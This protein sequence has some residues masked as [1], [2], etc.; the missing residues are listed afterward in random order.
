MSFYRLALNGSPARG[1]SPIGGQQQYFLSSSSKIL[2]Y[3]SDGDTNG[4]FYWLGTSGGTQSWENPHTAGRIDISIN[5]YFDSTFSNPAAAVDRVANTI[6]NG[7]DA[8]GWFKADLKNNK[9]IVS[10]YSI[11]GRTDQFNNNHLRT[12]QLQGSNDNSNWTVLDSQTNNSTINAGTWF[13]MI[14]SQSTEAYRYL[15]LYQP[16]AASDGEAFITMGEWEFYGTL[17]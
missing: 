13:T 6:T 2:A 4:V 1:R 9:L 7:G 15:R 8:P 11:R 12:W 17:I 3:S 16:G 14:L 10:A 5:S